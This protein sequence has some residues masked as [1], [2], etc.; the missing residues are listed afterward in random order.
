MIIV[1]L[2]KSEII[3]LTLTTCYKNYTT[4]F[5]SIYNTHIIIGACL[6]V[7]KN[8]QRGCASGVRWLNWKTSDRVTAFQRLVPTSRV[9]VRKNRSVGWR[10]CSD[11]DS[12]RI[13][14]Q[15]DCGVCEER[16]QESR[17]LQVQAKRNTIFF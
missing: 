5:N 4:P 11:L 14:V 13:L 2:L 3:C 8:L 6:I 9:L 15:K 17:C 12:S 7:Q 16:K 1:K 10:S